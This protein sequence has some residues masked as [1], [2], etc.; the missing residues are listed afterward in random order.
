[1]SNKEYDRLN[2]IDKKL[3]AIFPIEQYSQKH[4]QVT[5]EKICGFELFNTRPY[6]NHETWSDG[7]RALVNGKVICESEDLDDLVVEIEKRKCVKCLGYHHYNTKCESA[8]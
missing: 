2:P 6:H 3:R 7:Y 8:P 5:I 4:V 1:M